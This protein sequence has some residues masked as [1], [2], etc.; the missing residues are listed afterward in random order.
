MSQLPV[1]Q[2]SLQYR[3]IG[4][5]VLLNRSI[6]KSNDKFNERDFLM[7]ANKALF[8]CSAIYFFALLK[9]PLFDK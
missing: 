8:A 5:T 7:S 1:P 3:S 2:I 6:C 9:E 4:F